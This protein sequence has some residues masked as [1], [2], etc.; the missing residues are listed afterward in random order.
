MNPAFSKPILSKLKNLRCA[1]LSVSYGRINL[2]G[3]CLVLTLQT[4]NPVNHLTQNET[5]FPTLASEWVRAEI[6]NIVVPMSSSL[7]VLKRCKLLLFIL[8]SFFLSHGPLTFTRKE[9]KY[10]LFI[11]ILLYFRVRYSKTTKFLHLVHN[12]IR[13]RQDS[14]VL[15][16][17]RTAGASTV[18][19]EGKHL[20]CSSHPPLRDNSTPFPPLTN[21]N[22]MLPRR[23]FECSAL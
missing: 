15:A 22:A 17:A 1:K 10:K 20:H 16:A 6:K 13:W 21:W 23:P 11:T 3:L 9:A 14:T 5:N 2:A 7:C 4:S 19:K 8:V 12:E 18:C